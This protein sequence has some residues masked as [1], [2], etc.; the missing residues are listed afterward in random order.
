MPVLRSSHGY[1]PA[2]LKQYF[3]YCSLFPK[4]YCFSVQNLVWLWMAQ[5]YMQDNEENAMEN[6]GDAYFKELLSRSF[7]EKVDGG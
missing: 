3:V 6:I 5:G 4:Y 2:H 7:F 1:L